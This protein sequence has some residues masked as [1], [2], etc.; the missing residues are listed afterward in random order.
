MTV[1][2]PVGRA[3]QLALVA[4]LV[5]SLPLAGVAVFVLGADRNLAGDS[6]GVIFFVALVGLLTSPWWGAATDRP[7]ERH[8]KVHSAVMIWFGITFSTHLTW[9]LG[10]LVFRHAIQSAPQAI[11]AYPW[12]AYIDGGDARYAGNGALLLT[13]ETLSVCNGAMGATGLMLRRWVPGARRIALA[14]L[15]GTAVIHLV[16]TSI[17]FGSE[18]LAGCPNVDRSVVDFGIKFLLLNG[19]WLVMPW[20]VL[21]WG[22]RQ[23]AVKGVSTG[24]VDTPPNAQ[25]L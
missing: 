21:G 11:W 15:M 4:L 3:T 16:T 6:V 17:Y 9:E 24:G 20:F 10:W 25:L 19:V 1:L 2:S 18:L 23:L 14:M 8:D 5:A 7:V 13:L 22:R 12:W